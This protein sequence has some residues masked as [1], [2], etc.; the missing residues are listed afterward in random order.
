MSMAIVGDI[1]TQTASY[2][3]FGF[4]FAAAIAWMDVIRYMISQLVNVSRNGGPYYLLSAIFTSL[5]AIIM[6]NVLR[7]AGLSN[8]AAQRDQ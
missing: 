5:L 7:R 1:T 8:G 3:T 4:F 6:M 2:A